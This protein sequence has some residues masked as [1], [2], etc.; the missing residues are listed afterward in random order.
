[1][2]R[3]VSHLV[4]LWFVFCDVFC[5][6]LFVNVCARLQPMPEQSSNTEFLGL[7]AHANARDRLVGVDQ[8]LVLAPLRQVVKGL[9][10]HLHRGLLDAGRC[11][12]S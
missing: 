8:H 4:L 3:F 1:M 7:G 6:C 9:L 10:V 11:N 12:L 2:L 5:T